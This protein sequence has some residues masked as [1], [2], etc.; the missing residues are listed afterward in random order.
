[1]YTVQTQ[2]LVAKY[3]LYLY[4][5]NCYRIYTSNF[6]SANFETMTYVWIKI[7]S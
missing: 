1:M 6:T 4:L 5:F 2:V 7:Q 3:F